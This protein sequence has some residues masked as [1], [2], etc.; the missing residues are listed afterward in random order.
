MFEK[1]LLINKIEN[2]HGIAS[3]NKENVVLEFPLRHEN[4]LNRF[5]LI[6]DST[7]AQR[8]LVRNLYKLVHDWVLLNVTMMLNFY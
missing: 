6:T 2:K 1:L 7:E 3:E 8:F 5:F 4:T